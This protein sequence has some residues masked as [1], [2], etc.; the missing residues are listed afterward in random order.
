[1]VF[2]TTLLTT[3]VFE[4]FDHHLRVENV[5]SK[6]SCFLSDFRENQFLHAKLVK[7]VNNGYHAK[8]TADILFRSCG[9]I[10]L[11]TD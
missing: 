11:K 8:Q 10:S 6:V 4:N 5:C 7:N 1:M 9:V 2:L 3:L